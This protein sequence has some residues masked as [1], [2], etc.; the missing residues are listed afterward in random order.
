MQ[1]EILIYSQPPASTGSLQPS[2]KQAFNG[3]GLALRPVNAADIK[4]GALRSDHAKLF[5]LPGIVGEVSAYTDQLRPDALKEIRDFVERGQVMLTICAGTYF[6]SRKTVYDPP[7]GHPRGRLSAAPLFNAVARGPV[8]PHG[9]QPHP[10]S[11]FSDVT[12]VP[13]SYKTLDGQWKE[14]GVCYGNGAALY[15]DNDRCPDTEI[16]ARY[17]QAAGTPVA[18]LRHRLGKGA[19]Y[20]SGILPEI[21]YQKIRINSPGFQSVRTLMDDLKPH[22]AERQQL[23]DGLVTRIRRDLRLNGG[24]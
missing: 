7:W 6:I 23:W 8:A 18:M 20:M 12:V 21:A 11:R 15:P 2:L 3:D 4:A 9:R 1:S 19:I 5:V 13:V 24:P 22:E 14:G 17:R 16:L 10:S